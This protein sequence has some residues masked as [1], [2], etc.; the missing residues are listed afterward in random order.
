M[1]ALATLGPNWM[2]PAYL[3]EQYGGAFFWIALAIVFIECGLLF[4]ILP[5]DS[6]LFAMGLFIAT[7]QVKIHVVPAI[8]LLCIA[9]FLGNVSGY[10]I[11][12]ALGTPLYERQGRFINKK[13]FDKT[14]DFFDHHGNKA[15]VIGRFVPIVR[16]YITVVAGVS[17][18]E[19]K[20]FFTWSAIGA[21]AWVLGVMLLGFLLGQA[22]PGL[23][24]HIEAIILLIVAFSLVP[25]VF[26]WGRHKKKAAALAGDAATDAAPGVVDPARTDPDAR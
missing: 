4:P 15:L 8:L 25:M 24:D 5:G 10:E 14:R 18:M 11:G 3:L 16:T 12:R 13:N 21:V 26:E 19:R 2:D 9:A 1:H 23:Q 20:R 7:G 22:I 17:R 6:L